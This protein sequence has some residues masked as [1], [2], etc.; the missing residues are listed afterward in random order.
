MI[1]VEIRTS[2]KGALWPSQH[3]K[4]L[5]DALARGGAKRNPIDKYPD[6]ANAI[7]KLVVEKKCRY[8]PNT[9]TPLASKDDNAIKLISIQRVRD[10]DESIRIGIVKMPVTYEWNQ[11]PVNFFGTIGNS[12]YEAQTKKN[13]RLINDILDIRTD[14]WT[15]NVCI[16]FQLSTHRKDR[17]LDNLV[18]AII[19]EFNSKI[20]KIHKILVIKEDACESGIELLRISSQDYSIEIEEPR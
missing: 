11:I 6:L 16:S 3:Y 5:I 10:G 4:S 13:R 12:K 17:D 7:N 2:K 14:N 18:D 1:G 15:E 20:K 19:P 8:S 9:K